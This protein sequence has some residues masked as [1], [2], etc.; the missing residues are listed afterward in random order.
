[1]ANF[2]KTSPATGVVVTGGASG[3]GQ[4]C[5]RALAEAGR[6]VSL[7]DLNGDGASD[8]AASIST[9][10]GVT[11][12]ALGLD[13]T[14]GAAV[15]DAVVAAREA[16]GSIGGLVHAAGIVTAVDIDHL[17]EEVWDSVLGV[18]LRAQAFVV[19][20]LLDDLRGH[21]GSAVVGIGSI[22]SVV[23]N[24]LIPSYTSS[25]HGVVGLTKSLAN[26]LGPDGVRVN[27][28]CPGYID[29]PM[30][31]PSLSDPATKASLEAKSPLGRV[32]TPVDIAK[33]VRFLMS[34]EAGFVTG[35]TLV[36]DGGV[37]SH[38]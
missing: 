9:D 29:T 8:A 17:T 21:Q 14:D 6:P 7:W 2:L 24:A 16:L 33:A 25:K 18:N 36:V 34:D 26:H 4:A 32:G 27:A 35:T 22:M 19:K 1:M 5:A 28:V 15:A 23:G 3:I 20:A 13:V 10:C 30:M 11:T 12:H 38:D 37:T 31:G